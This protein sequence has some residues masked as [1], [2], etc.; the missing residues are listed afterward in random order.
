MRVSFSER[1]LSVAG[2]VGVAGVAG[3]LCFEHQKGAVRAVQVDDV[4]RA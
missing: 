2:V 4:P 3:G 1:R